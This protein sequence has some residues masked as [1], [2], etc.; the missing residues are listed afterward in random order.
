MTVPDVQL[1]E[2]HFSHLLEKYE[3]RSYHR[4]EVITGTIVFFEK[5]VMYVDIGAERDALVPARELASVDAD[6]LDRLGVGKKIPVF[7][8]HT[9]AF[10]GELIVSINRGLNGQDWDL[11]QSLFETG[12]VKEYPVVDQN[13]G[14]L[15]VKIGHLT[16]FVPNSQINNIRRQPQE[17]REEARRKM[18]G[19][20]LSLKVIDVNSLEERLVL[21]ELAAL[22]VL[23]RQ[24][25]ES[26]MVGEVILSEVVNLAPFG[27]FV[28]LGGIDGLV[29][30]SN[31]C[32]EK[33]QHPAEVVSL[34][35]SLEVQVVE[36][37]LERE[38]VSLSRKVLL[39]NPMEQYASIHKPGEW[40][41][42]TV[43]NVPEFGVFIRLTDSVVGLLHTSEM[44]D[45]EDRLPQDIFHSGDR[46]LVRLV[47]LNHQSGR[48]S[49]SLRPEE[50]ETPFDWTDQES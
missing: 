23:R 5:D 16:G 12:E 20:T 41:E 2:D 6:V 9:P 35:E 27:V 50:S 34:G 21:S 4:G 24:R 18:L 37:N 38:R 17:Q 33:V 7:V 26:L 3:H 46:V 47:E 42:G 25:L 14:G 40:V 39:P 48:I 43:D 28:D 10:G 11:A 19:S 36:I 44:G 30:I 31:L 8:E 45:Y 49:L 29:H 22:S 1:A 13:R 15:L 32:W